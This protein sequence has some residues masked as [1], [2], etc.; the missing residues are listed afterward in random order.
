MI[1]VNL[2]AYILQSMW[3]E[4]LKFLLHVLKSAYYKILQLY[5]SKQNS[6]KFGTSTSN[7]NFGVFLVRI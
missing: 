6:P 1:S 3:Q 7:D 2:N 4:F 5:V